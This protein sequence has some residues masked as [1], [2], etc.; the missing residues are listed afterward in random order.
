MNKIGECLLVGT[1]S[2]SCCVTVC[3]GEFNPTAPSVF[4]AKFRM[5]CDGFAGLSHSS[6]SS[7]ARVGAEYSLDLDDVVIAHE[8]QIMM[9]R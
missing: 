8:R 4:L 2:V 7:N 9:D 1:F 3:E 6:S 5:R